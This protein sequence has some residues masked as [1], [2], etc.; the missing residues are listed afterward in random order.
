MRRRTI[1]AV[2]GFAAILAVAVL[3]VFGASA[4][5]FAGTNADDSSG[6]PVLAQTGYDFTPMLVT[7]AVFLLIAGIT[8]IVAKYVL[9][10]SGAGQ[11]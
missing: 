6:E 5:A 10:R 3:S 4:A 11:N 2:S 7:A 1:S 8:V 9:S